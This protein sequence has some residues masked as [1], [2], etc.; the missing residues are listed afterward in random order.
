M[1]NR[2]LQLKNGN[3]KNFDCLAVAYEMKHGKDETYKKIQA[4][5]IMA[6]LQRLSIKEERKLIANEWQVII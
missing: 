3:Y 6:S 2:I 1:I 4:A 5:S